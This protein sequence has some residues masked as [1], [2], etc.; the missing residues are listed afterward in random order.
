MEDGITG[1]EVAEAQSGVAVVVSAKEGVE[2]AWPSFSASLV[3]SLSVE[4]M[5]TVKEGVLTSAPSLNFLG[6]FI[7]VNVALGR[8]GVSV[9]VPEESLLTIFI[10]ELQAVADHV[11]IS[12]QKSKMKERLTIISVILGVS[13]SL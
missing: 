12:E 10:P 8:K 13:T 1:V 7:L 6:V 2:D 11:I 9:A 4:S 3:S 5:V